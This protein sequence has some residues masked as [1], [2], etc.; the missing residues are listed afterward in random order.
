MTKLNSSEFVQ[1]TLASFDPKC[2]SF[3][4]HRAFPVV[5]YVEAG[6]AS[7]Q[8]GRELSAL[9]RSIL[10]EL[11][12]EVEEFRTEVG[13]FCQ[14][15]ICG[16]R[17]PLDE[18]S[19]REKIGH[20]QDVVSENLAKLPMKRTVSIAGSA[21]VAVVAIGTAV[22]LV[23]SANPET[24]TIGRFIVPAGVRVPLLV[25]KETCDFLREVRAIFVE[26]KAA[27]KALREAKLPP[28][29]IRLADRGASSP[30]ISAKRTTERTDRDDIIARLET[31]LQQA[32]EQLD[33]LKNE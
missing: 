4:F 17:V 22:Q 28:A 33:K 32:Q 14:L 12:F 29:K 16:S 9:V 30:R 25:A 20:A 2:R 1:L 10:S 31:T 8:I 11:G 15:N 23:Q 21:V 3:A 26:S 18:P 27:R 13:S 5:V 6:N 19:L 24:V 7:S